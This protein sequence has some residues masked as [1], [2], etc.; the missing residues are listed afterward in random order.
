MACLFDLLL[1]RSKILRPFTS[2]VLS[3]NILFSSLFSTALANRML[4]YS[5]IKRRLVW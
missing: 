4:R 3:L 1:R 5:V 2:S